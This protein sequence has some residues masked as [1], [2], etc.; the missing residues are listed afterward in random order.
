[1]KL[2]YP[3]LTYSVL[4][5]VQCAVFLYSWVMWGRFEF[6]KVVQPS[7]AITPSVR[8]GQHTILGLD[9]LTWGVKDR[10]SKLSEMSWNGSTLFSSNNQE[11][12]RDPAW[13]QINIYTLRLAQSDWRLSL[14]H[15]QTWNATFTFPV[16]WKQAGGWGVTWCQHR[17]KYWDQ[18]NVSRTTH[19][20]GGD[21]GGGMTVSSP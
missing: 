15:R 17:D 5:C 8:P 12:V 3:V 9:W 19:N 1:M 6:H 20:T 10:L 18:H 7:P 16:W 14:C 2:K 11:K 13:Q 4:C 21:G